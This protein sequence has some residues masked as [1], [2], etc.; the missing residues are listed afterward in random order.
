MSINGLIIIKK[1]NLPKIENKL[2]EIIASNESEHHGLAIISQKRDK[3]HLRKV[4]IHNSIPSTKIIRTYTNI[5]LHST[6]PFQPFEND[7]VVLTSVGTTRSMHSTIRLFSSITSTPIQ[8]L[9]SAINNISS[10]LYPFS[11]S[12]VFKNDPYHLYLVSQGEP[13]FLYY[14][15]SLHTV[16]FSSYSD[17]SD[18]D[19]LL[20]HTKI[21]QLPFHT[22]T[23]IST[24]GTIKTYP[25]QKG[26]NND[27]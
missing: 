20:A 23:Q 16:F 11:L 5:I 18:P 19:E 21:K 6:V 1:Q 2:R 10:P 22:I 24:Y 15:H 12:L 17:F 26:I 7:H 25:L 4:T 13:I 14:N 8:S 27:N 3:L 9:V